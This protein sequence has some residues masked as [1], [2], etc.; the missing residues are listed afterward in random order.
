LTRLTDK[1][2]TC[3]QTQSS[4]DLCVCVCVL[5]HRSDLPTASINNRNTCRNWFVRCVV[6][7]R[8]KNDSETEYAND[9]FAFTAL[10]NV[11]KLLTK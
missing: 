1:G 7:E 11:R 4:C 3:R 8:R 10:F 6:C 5:A 9:F 2:T